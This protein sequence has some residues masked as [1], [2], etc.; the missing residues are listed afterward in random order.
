MRPVAV[1]LGEGVSAEDLWI[2]DENDI[3]K[4]QVLVRMFDDPRIEGHFPRPFGVFYK[5]DR[6]TYEEQM[7]LQIEETI[8]AK[9]K[10]DLDKLLKGRET[11]QIQ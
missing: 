1:E 8:A 4:A 6:P 9:G 10:G 11:W 7:T 3:Y 2:H 5:V